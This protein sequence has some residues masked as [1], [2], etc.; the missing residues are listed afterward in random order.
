LMRERARPE[1]ASTFRPGR[2]SLRVGK[3]RG[4]YFN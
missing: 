4:K 3:W 2:R 1:A